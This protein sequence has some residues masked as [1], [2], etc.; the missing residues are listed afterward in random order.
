MSTRFF[1]NAGDNTLLNKFRGIFEHNKDIEYFDALVGFLRASGYFSIRPFLQHVPNIR[2]LVGIN[3]DTIIS[4]YHKQGLLFH[5]DSDRAID[6]FRKALRDDIQEARYTKEVE[7]GIVQFVDDVVAKKLEIRAHPSKRLHAKIYIFRPIGFNEHKAGAVITGSSNLTDAGLGTKETRRNY[8]FNVLLNSF[9]D[10]QFATHEFETLWEEGV[11]ILPT[12]ILAVREHSYLR[13]DLT[14]FELYIKFLTEYFGSAV[15]FDPNAITDLP[16]GFMRLSY[17]IDAVKLGYDLLH[18]H[19]G[20]FLADVVGLG[21]TIIATLIAKKFFFHNDFPSYLSRILIIVPPALKESWQHAIDK[22]ELKTAE[23]VTNGSLHKIK[24]P[25]KYD[26]IIVDEAHKFR[27]DTAESYDQLQR[28]CKA[29]TR[30]RLT[31]GTLAKKKVILVSATPLNN[32]PADIRNLLFLFQDGKDSTLEIGNLQRFFSNRIKEYETALR[33]PNTAVA[34]EAVKRIYESIRTKVFSYLTIRRTRTDL[35][36]HDAYRNDLIE[37]NIVFPKVEKPTKI[38]YKL[39]PTLEL[40][41]DRTINALKNDL[42]YNRYRAI[43]FLKPDKKR[44]YQNADRISSQLAN[45]MKTLLVK[46]LDSSFHAFT[47]SLLRF[48]N[49]TSAMQSM[50]E[51]GTIYI[52]PN[53]N[54]SSYILEGREDDLIALIAEKQAT[55]PTIEICTPEDFESGYLAGLQADYETLEALCKQWVKVKNDPKFEEFLVYLKTE[56]FDRKNNHGGKLVIFSEAKETTDHLYRQL[57]AHGYDKVLCIDSGNRAEKMPSVRANFDANIPL[58]QQANEYSIVISTEVLAEGVNL[59]RAN[60]IVNYDTPWNSTRL[61]QRIGRVNR[62]GTTASKIH[63]YNFFPTA[64]VDNDI[65]L[66]KKALMKLQ[67]FHSALGEDSQIYSQDEEFGTFGLFDRDVEEERDERLAFLMELRKFKVD[68][69]E[70]FRRIRNLPLRARTG[71]EQND[72]NGKTV[73]FIR[74]QRR[75]A[76]YRVGPDDEIEE[77]SFVETARIYQANIDESASPLHDRHHD[78]VNLALDDFAGKLQAE[79]VQHKVVDTA[80]GPNER[81]ALSYL[82][83]FLKLPF[84][85]EAEKHRIQAAKHAIK[86]ARFAQLQRGVNDLAKSQKKTPVTAVA[87]LEKLMEILN[88]YPLG[89]EFEE[90][91]HPALAVKGTDELRPEIIISESFTS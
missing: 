53:L 2:I 45:I 17:Q 39:E 41:Y 84:I 49:A 13:S 22:F 3:V 30:H 8:E 81:K 51:N 90:A 86:M 4:D 67:A 20:F 11:S 10:V 12:D 29:P 68:N 16:H 19:N 26:L 42:T 24:Q 69:P 32:R 18:K 71:R 70:K 75:D 25:E 73:T 36:E 23:I 64:K 62:I 82:D 59:H 54:V 88:R 58:D 35:M 44:K 40:L 33:N 47:E 77:L 7:E 31:D 48:K 57:A 9:E 55:D 46:R 27:N 14:P 37:Q 43:G 76:F 28:I 89:S 34:R 21:K 74:N 61:M 72:L 65:E 15:E 52:A 1:T 78:H 60:V 50:F 80:Q 5:P 6:E 56:L 83:G 63:I 66:H 79:A 85:S 38:L 87:L 91:E